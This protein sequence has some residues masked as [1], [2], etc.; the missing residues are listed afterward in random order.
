MLQR[1]VKWNSRADCL[2][3]AGEVALSDPEAPHLV[4]QGGTFKAEAVDGSAV[5]RDLSRR[6]LLC[7][8]N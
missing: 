5:T 4:L 7:I 2:N 6:C 8:E 1:L 3:G